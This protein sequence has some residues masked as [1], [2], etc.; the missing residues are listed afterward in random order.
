[1]TICKAEPRH[2]PGMIDLLRQVGQVHHEIR[3]DIFC[4]G[5][6]KYDAQALEA[7]LAES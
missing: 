5:A 4:S 1:M 3:P 2:I 6:L 7:L